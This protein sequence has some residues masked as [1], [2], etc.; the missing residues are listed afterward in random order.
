MGACS[1][2]TVLKFLAGAQN[3]DGGWGYFAGEPSWLEPTVWAAFA[4]EGRAGYQ[5]QADAAF[6]AARGW[7]RP[8]GSVR[9][10]PDIDEPGWAGALW[11]AWHVARGHDDGP[12]RRGIQWLTAERGAE[13]ALW[14][15]ALGR[16][17][18]TERGYEPSHF[19][20]PW[21]TGTNSWVEPTA[22]SVRALRAVLRTGWA[23]VDPSGEIRW[24]VQLGERM[25]LDRRGTDG[26]WNY[27]AREALGEALPSYPETTG[28]ALATLCNWQGKERDQ[29][30]ER[31]R[32]WLEEHISPLAGAWLQLALRLHSA[33]IPGV[34]ANPGEDVLTASIWSLGQPD[35]N[36]PLVAGEKV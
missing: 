8:D 25:L 7:Q 10:Q 15:R 14:R 29:S 2:Q 23:A 36:Y 16:L 6:R 26:G 31:A 27:G 19:G 13:G 24:R 20:W 4:L 35:G 17:V 12:L 34:L 5:A 21:R 11:V 1:Q 32:T 9:V 28:V 22:H 30:I 18:G 3:K 33:S